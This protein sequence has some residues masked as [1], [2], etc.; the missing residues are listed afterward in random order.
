[1]GKVNDKRGQNTGESTPEII[2]QKVEEVIPEAP[3][4]SKI[5][6]DMQHE[7]ILLQDF[8][9]A[10]KIGSI[11]TPDGR[12]V[13]INKARVVGIGDGV[14]NKKLKLGTVIY[15]VHGLGQTLVDSN[16]QSFIFLPENSVIA[17]DT[18]F[19]SEES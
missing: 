19:N 5:N 2:Q 9:P 10:N 15:K 4:Y 7:R 3:D 17:I 16:G 12:E 18:N 6:L 1:M 11:F 8:P 13:D 14:R